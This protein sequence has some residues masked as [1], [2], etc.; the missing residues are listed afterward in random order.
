MSTYLHCFLFL[1][2]S[3]TTA[4]LI[5]QESANSSLTIFE[6]QCTLRRSLVSRVPEYHDCLRAIDRLPTRPEHEWGP[7]HNG[8][9]ED[10]YQLPVTKV[11]GSCKVRVEL[12]AGRAVF[13]ESWAGLK[14][15]AWLLNHICLKKVSGV[16][17]LHA[18]GW[19]T[20]GS[21]ERIVITLAS[22]YEQGE[23]GGSNLT[24]G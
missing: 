4:L 15:A 14:G 7:F 22:P 8:P 16:A 19:T 24:L 23:V 13:R 20:W 21:H 9:P 5:P 17:Q 2:V 6:N 11:Q 3:S 18:G 1:V 12:R 10:P